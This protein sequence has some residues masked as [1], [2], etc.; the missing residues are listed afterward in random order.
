ML[1][2]FPPQQQQQDSNCTKD[3]DCTTAFYGTG[4]HAC[5]EGK[6]RMQLNVNDH[7]TNSSDCAGG[8][9]CENKRCQGLAEGAECTMPFRP[10]HRPT[11]FGY[12]NYVCGEGLAC[13]QADSGD[14]HICRPAKKENEA[15]DERTPCSIYL[16]CNAGT[17]VKPHS[18]AVGK[19]CTVCDTLS[20]CQHTQSSPPFFA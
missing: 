9:A 4:V 10:A 12:T 5:V 16:V 11:N 18:V 6:C 13:A 3:E 8:M 14:K 2:L 19:P 15:C 20:Y 7:C 17:C 1:T